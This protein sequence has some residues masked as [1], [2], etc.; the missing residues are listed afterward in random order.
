MK[1][2]RSA[3]LA[4]ICIW[5]VCAA[6]LPGRA[7]EAS[8]PVEIRARSLDAAGALFYVP[9]EGSAAAALARGL[10][11]P[12]VQKALSYVPGRVGQAV[13]VTNTLGRHESSMLVYDAL[14]NVSKR[15]GTVA[16]WVRSPWDGTD[17][18][19]LTG[20]AYTGPTILSMAGRELNS[21]FLWFCRRK[22]F[23][24]MRLF[25]E[26]LA[27]DLDRFGTFSTALIP[28]WK[29]D[30]WQ[31][32]AFVWDD[33][34]GYTFFRNGAVL[35][36]VRG[37]IAWDMVT[38]DNIA[39]GHAT[40]HAGDLW[41]VSGE[42]AFDEFIVFASAL[43]S[44]A[45]GH[46]MQG[47]YGQ[48]PGFG[49]DDWPFDADARRRAANLQDHANRPRVAA[50]P[51]TGIAIDWREVPTESV[52]M[53]YHRRY[54]LVD[55]D[56]GS[57][58]HFT[59]GGVPFDTP[60]SLQF[61]RPSTCNLVIAEMSEPAGAWIADAA[62]GTGDRHTLVSG[63]T[64]VP[65][66]PGVRDRVRAFFPAKATANELTVANVQIA[67]AAAAASVS[68]QRFEL[69]QSL[70][71]NRFPDAARVMLQ[72]PHPADRCALLA[73]RA[74]ATTSGETVHR[75]KLTHT[76][77]VLA[78]PEEE[79]FVDALRLKLTV[80][81]ANADFA[82][83]VRIHCPQIEG[84]IVLEA[85]F[86]AGWPAAA[87]AL[88]MTV[89][90]RPAGLIVPAGS[91]LVIDLVSDTALD[92]ISGSER[93]SSVEIVPGDEAR[94][95]HE[96]ALA[97]LRHMW[98]AF[99]RRL[100]QNRFLRPGEDRETNP[101]WLGLTRA[102]R[103]DPTNPQVQTWWGWSRLRPWPPYDFS[104]LAAQEGPRWA[105]T[106]REAVHSMQ[107][108]IHWWLENRASPDAYLVG[109]GNQ[110]N[111]ITKLYNK[112]LCLGGVT[113]D[114]RL[115]NAV[116]RYLDA[117][118]NT[119]RMID[120]YI[121]YMTD[122]THSCEEASY[123]QPCLH[124]LRPG[125]PRHIYRDL[126]TAENYQTWLG[127]NAVGHT[128]FRSNVFTAGDM[129]TE[130]VHGRDSGGCA[131]ATVPGRTLWWATGHPPTA[132]LM[133]AHADAWLADTLRTEDD[134][135]AGMIPGAVDFQSDRLFPSYTYSE[136]TG[137]AFLDAFQ[138]TGDPA[139][140]APFE[141]V[142]RRGAGLTSGRWP[143]SW[144]RRFLGMWTLTNRQDL[145][146]D[147]AQ[148]ADETL[149]NMREDAFFQRGI[150]RE[151]AAALLRWVT[152]HDLDDLMTVLH[153]VIRNNR[154]GFHPYCMT[155]PPTDRVYP[156]GRVALPVAMLGGRL[157]D[158]RAAG[159]LPTSAF[160]WDG[161]DA[162]TV[163]LVLGQTAGEVSMVVHN[164]KE[165]VVSAGLR[166]VRM[167]EGEYDLSTAPDANADLAPDGELHTQRVTL[168]RF[169]PGQI[170]LP[171]RQSTCI[172][173]HLVTP[174]AKV[175]RP[176]LAL[177]L[178]EP[179]MQD[180]A[181]V[182]LRLHNLGPAPAS[183]VRVAV[184][185][186]DGSRLTEVAVDDLPGLTG[187]SPSICDLDVELPANVDA[188]ACIAVADPDDA[189]S[190]INESN[191]RCSLSGAP[192]PA[193]ESDA[194]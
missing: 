65:L 135:P 56:P 29:A 151:E 161:I 2:Q 165:N 109:G 184:L 3:G 125:V 110:W 182:H 193:V 146:A 171:P 133:K 1:R 143:L 154:R 49:A 150:E 95:G 24:D 69:T 103:Y 96:F 194:R 164:F 187:Y 169:T 37:D 80:R 180:A 34:H 98:P 79:T 68:G 72:T 52:H 148:L 19:I 173:L 50:D 53:A 189:L 107:A 26:R 122:I 77:I 129:D 43:D 81:P 159:P 60:A 27:G 168:R 131:A 176:D 191:N 82:T 5:I 76:Y 175:P 67:S 57:S 16:F 118:W 35:H 186:A 74:P 136:L 75:P 192:P 138:M 10:G 94:I 114:T 134:K 100:N 166:T 63:R 178:T 104:Y 4:I 17:R 116:E 58:V 47:E 87:T 44:D 106:L 45:I 185:G 85:V 9:F 97:Q 90:L 179:T 78:A 113:A 6:A 21:T 71:L 163:S 119:G 153:Y 112:F 102:E 46:V 108:I 30:E 15:R 157:F 59:D 73:S 11:E 32:F 83:Q 142:L 120:G 145:P 39:L 12:R 38:P 41:P 170:T 123:I 121:Y 92:I 140:L 36:E 158:G 172:R 156:W 152:S 149:K 181:V 33:R 55:G 144:A 64:Y 62:D 141:A 132:A 86:D 88:P 124:V 51:E 177:T 155:D 8:V 111:D 42:F 89:T 137:E 48:L 160:I 174:R 99:L 126:L 93:V 128:H 28:L 105:V 127:K 70:P 25:G 23:F 13:S 115:V 18:S 22:S 40:L 61:A 84:R 54:A 162:D 14:G 130:G 188:R 183:N 7:A 66:T 139:Y 117:H 91:H 147:L 167:P 190:E 31:H 101:I 20:S